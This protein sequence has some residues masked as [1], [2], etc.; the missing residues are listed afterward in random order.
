[1]SASEISIDC[2]KD[3]ADLADRIDGDNRDGSVSIVQ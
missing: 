1:M 2:F 3:R